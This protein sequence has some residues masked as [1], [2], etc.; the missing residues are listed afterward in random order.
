[1]A[2][3][4]LERRLVGERVAG[5]ARLL[6]VVE[7][8]AVVGEDRPAVD[9]AVHLRVVA[10]LE[11]VVELGL[12]LRLREEDV[13]VVG[14]VEVE[15]REVELGAE[16][17]LHVALPGQ[18]VVEQVLAGLRE[19]LLPSRKVAEQLVGLRPLARG[20]VRDAGHVDGGARRGEV[21]ALGSRG[22]LP[23]GT[24]A[25]DGDRK[26]REQGD[27]QEPLDAHGLGHRP[28]KVEP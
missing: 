12:V 10:G 27:P 8:P 20:R 28:A 7:R 14:V 5:L 6:E 15:Q 24:A 25:G 13:V 3:G 2:H 21:G 1:M 22:C 26:D 23:G 19:Q 11:Q 17:G 16:G 4:V 9:L 18:A